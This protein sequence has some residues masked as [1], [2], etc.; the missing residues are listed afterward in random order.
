MTLN[1]SLLSSQW[2]DYIIF[3]IICKIYSTPFLHLTSSHNTSAFVTP[4]IKELCVVHNDLN[5]Y[6]PVSNPCFRA[7]ILEEF[8]LSQV[9]S[10]HN[11]NNLYNTFQS[12]CRPGHSTEA[13]LR[14]VS[15]ELFLSLNK[16][17]MSML[18]LIYFSLALDIIDHS[19]LVHRLHTDFGFPDTGLQCS[20]SYL[21]DRTQYDSLS[22]NCSAFVPVH[23]GVP[24]G[25][26]LGP[27]L[28][29]MYTKPLYI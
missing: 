10:Y 21:T 28:F 7:E 23:T 26:A 24:Q 5:N 20:S 27:I 1:P 29:T 14:K 19:I 6:R 12:A 3:S 18:S 13:G 25:S 16:D 15:G 8:V 2:N 4:T 17:T 11:I 22:I 9:S